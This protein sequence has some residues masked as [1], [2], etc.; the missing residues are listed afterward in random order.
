MIKIVML[1]VQ[2]SL[3][4]DPAVET[5]D[6][7]SWKVLVLG[8]SIRRGSNLSSCSGLETTKYKT[9]GKTNNAAPF[10]FISLILI[11]H[12]HHNPHFH[13]HSHYIHHPYSN[14][15]Q[16]HYKSFVTSFSITRSYAVYAAFSISSSSSSSSSFWLQ[17]SRMLWRF[18]N[19]F[20]F[21][22]GLKRPRN[23]SE[24]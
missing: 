11:R 22:G 6:Y 15:L 10:S 2:G 7:L 1:G 12:F 17:P 5:Q 19:L 20:G 14:H 9:N 16:Y 3:S 13:R 24:K 18:D 21:L 8:V 23:K 4:P